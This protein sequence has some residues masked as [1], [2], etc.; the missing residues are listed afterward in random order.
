[1]RDQVSA[2]YLLNIG[3]TYLSEE[4]LPATLPEAER[5]RILSV[6]NREEQRRKI[7]AQ[8]LLHTILNCLHGIEV[9]RISRD[10]WGRPFLADHLG[11]SIG[12]SHSGD[13]VMCGTGPQ[14]KGIGLGVDIEAPLGADWT[15]FR[16]FL[17]SEEISILKKIT[18]QSRTDLLS[19]IW[20]CK[21]AY[22]K[23]LG[24][25]LSGTP[26]DIALDPCPPEAAD[27]ADTTASADTAVRLLSPFGEGSQLASPGAEILKSP[28]SR[29]VKISAGKIGAYYFA[30][31]FP[32]RFLTPHMAV[33]TSLKE[34]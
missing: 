9:P 21:E 3:K 27:T 29:E 32:S 7:G 19:R 16:S 11:L 18:P 31:C 15:S 2:I 6:S 24:F 33:I 14:H 5:D 34:I 13:Y 22:L 17:A 23:A 10:G 25:G 12:I 28:F 20:V 26:S 30:V 4:L 1:M 8:L